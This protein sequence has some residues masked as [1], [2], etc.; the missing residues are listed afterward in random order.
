M[1][2]HSIGKYF[3]YQSYPLSLS[4]LF[5]HFEIIKKGQTNQ[6]TILAARSFIK[7]GTSKGERYFY[8]YM[9][10][11]DTWNSKIKPI[12]DKYLNNT[13]ALHLIQNNLMLSLDL[14]NLKNY[15]P[16]S[17]FLNDYLNH[18]P[19]SFEETNSV[20]D[21]NNFNSSV[22]F[23]NFQHTTSFK[24]LKKMYYSNE[25][26]NYIVLNEDSMYFLAAIFEAKNLIDHIL[27]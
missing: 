23:E 19:I 18:I 27:N 7:I 11:K 4:D 2:N 25:S 10:E 12:L 1:N 26:K 15:V 3:F 20:D 6:T 14:E 8:I 22:L 9:I 5:P 16:N 13:M 21:M 24:M 17:Q